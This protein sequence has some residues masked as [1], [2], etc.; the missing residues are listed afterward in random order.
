MLVGVSLGYDCA[1]IRVCLGFVSGTHTHTFVSKIGLRW[2]FM[3]VS[4]VLL[5]LFRVC[6]GSCLGFTYSLF[7]YVYGFVCVGFV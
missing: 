7:R 2:G 4:F 3:K 5:G 6:L 1:M